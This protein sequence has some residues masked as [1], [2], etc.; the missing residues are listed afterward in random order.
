MAEHESALDAA[1]V[2]K[3]LAG[4]LSAAGIDVYGGRDPR[5]SQWDD[6]VAELDA[7]SD[8]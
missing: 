7:T 1:Q 3:R 8:R 6:L 4:K 2:A 5:I